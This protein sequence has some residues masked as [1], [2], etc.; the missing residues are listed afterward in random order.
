VGVVSGG[1]GG[2]DTLMYRL[3]PR[4]CKSCVDVCTCPVPLVQKMHSQLPQT[5]EHKFVFSFL[6]QS[7]STVVEIRQKL[8][9]IK[10]SID[11]IHTSFHD[12]FCLH[13]LCSQPS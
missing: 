2:G 6:S 13:Y 7:V 5:E 9:K 4:P 11:S 3:S 12:T 1:V 10:F 8:C